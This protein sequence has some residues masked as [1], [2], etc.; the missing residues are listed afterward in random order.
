MSQEYNCTQLNSQIKFF[1]NFT[2]LM[3]LLSDDVFLRRV[4]ARISCWTR[5]MTRSYIRN[6][7][8]K[9]KCLHHHE[10]FHLL[11]AVEQHAESSVIKCKQ[12]GTTIITTRLSRS[13]SAK[14]SEMI[15]YEENVYYAQN[16]YIQST[17]TK[18]AY[19]SLSIE[20]IRWNSSHV[21]LLL[22]FKSSESSMSRMS[23]SL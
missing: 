11:R 5:A 12:N 14:S 6:V 1:L 9:S 4:V 10:C 2:R 19:D 20:K 16:F 18:A 21:K 22:W 15:R 17:E 7:P 23:V 13:E 8:V 3:N